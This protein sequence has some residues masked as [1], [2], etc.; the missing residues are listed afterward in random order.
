MSRI[1]FAAVTAIAFLTSACLH[2]TY[3]VR[4]PPR[5]TAETAS[6]VASCQHTRGDY[7]AHYECLERCPGIEEVE[8]S[9]PD[10]EREAAMCYETEKTDVLGSIGVGV[11]TFAI[12][13]AVG[14]VALTAAVVDDLDDGWEGIAIG[15]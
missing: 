9:C 12:V 3:R 14:M 11:V 5:V 15:Y 13:L 4:V 8:A 1:L 7:A 6:C 2:D 10:E